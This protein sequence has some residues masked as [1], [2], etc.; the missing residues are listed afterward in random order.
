MP[1]IQIPLPGEAPLPAD[2]DPGLVDS[3]LAVLGEERAET[4]E[5]AWNLDLPDLVDGEEVALADELADFVGAA[6]FAAEAV[7]LTVP[8]E[9]WS[10]QRVAEVVGAAE[11]AVRAQTAV[12][13]RATAVLARR[14]PDAGG[15][16]EEEG[17]S[18]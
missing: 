13:L 11:R 3:A 7:R 6:G 5:S 4:F 14:R 9:D 15:D 18:A 17:L 10:D 8:C 12:G 2:P 16:P 1:V